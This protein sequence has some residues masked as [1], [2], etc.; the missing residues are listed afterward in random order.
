VL[1]E[2]DSLIVLDKREGR[3]VYV[4]N[5]TG[6]TIGYTTGNSER[7]FFSK[8]FHVTKFEL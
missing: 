8:I 6:E 4:E 1:A 7:I 5:E 3:Y 2:K